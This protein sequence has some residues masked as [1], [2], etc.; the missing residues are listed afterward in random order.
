MEAA[1]APGKVFFYVIGL[2]Q[3]IDVNCEERFPAQFIFG[4]SGLQLSLSLSLS[5]SLCV[6]VCVCVCVVCVSLS[7]SL[8]F[9]R[10]LKVHLD[11]KSV[12][13]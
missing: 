2:M 1:S 4:C 6:C 12:F 10:A 8:S 11:S 13:D 3:L 9:I 5:L 7:L